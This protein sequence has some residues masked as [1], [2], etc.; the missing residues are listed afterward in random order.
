MAEE[1]VNKE[2]FEVWIR[3]LDKKVEALS[4][5]HKG[6]SDNTLRSINILEREVALIK[7][8]LSRSASA[9]G[10]IGGM[11]PVVIAIAIAIMKDWP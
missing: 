4:Q 2:V 11:I 6:C 10:M 1:F 9:W 8:K 3:A 7:M 5:M